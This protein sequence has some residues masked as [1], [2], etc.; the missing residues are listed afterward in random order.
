LDKGAPRTSLAVF[1]LLA[2]VSLSALAVRDGLSDTTVAAA[3]S[4]MSAWTA[5]GVE[6]GEQT[7][8]WVREDLQ[9]AAAMV[10]GDPAP[11]ELLGVLASR[12]L[13]DPRNE[14]LARDEFR[15][16]IEL[17]PSSPYN[18]LHL[19]ELRYQTGDTGALFE[20]DLG[21]AASLGPSE[22]GVQRVVA[23]LGLA[24]YDDLSDAGRRTVDG[25]IRSGARRNALEMMQ[26]STR[27]GRLDVTCRLVQSMAPEIDPK[28]SQLCQRTGATS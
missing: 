3:D 27:R 5:S 19:A 26:I 22:P 13:G 18:W 14:Q 10:P 11:H 15:A 1:V 12:D 2:A 17:R 9:R 25:A 16:S 4:E 28:A 6:P 21:R 7:Q 24:V 23:F 8:R 20:R